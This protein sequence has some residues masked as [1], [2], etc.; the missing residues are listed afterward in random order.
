MSE[1]RTAVIVGATGVVG[2]NLIHHLSEIGGWRVVG[3]SRREPDLPPGAEWI[4]V[5]LLDA[6]EAREKLAPL[7][8]ATHLFY[9]G[10]VNAPNVAANVGPNLALLANSVEALSAAAPGLEHV[11]LIE[12]TK[13]YGSHLG[14]FK[15]PAKEDDPRHMPPNFYYDQQDWLAAR[16]AESSWTWSA[17]RPHAICGF[18]LGNP[19]N[20]TMAIAV[21]AEI[22]KELDLPL[23]FPGKP[24]AYETLYQ[25][26][27][28]TLLAKAMVW[29]ATTPAAAN[30]AFNMTNGDVF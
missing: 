3:L 15:T 11:S 17:L 24:R 4:G 16:Q 13:W 26:S 27:D 20:L 5:D 29:A 8:H 9:G 22:S 19:M 18:A 25:A 21:Y 12:G 23:R 28:S 14:P 7:G 30:Q 6:R 10:L 2:R 1:A